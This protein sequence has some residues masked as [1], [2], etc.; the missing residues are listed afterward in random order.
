MSPGHLRPLFL[1]VFAILVIAAG[2]YLSYELGR[3]RAGYSLLD[4][5]RQTEIYEAEIARLE[6]AVEDLRR[7]QAIF[8]TSR[9]I[10]RE[11]YA[12]VESNLDQQQ[13][14]IQA[15]EEELAFYRGIVSPQDGKAGLR[16]QNLQV[17]PSDSEQNHVLKLMLVQAIM[18]SNRVSG[19]VRVKLIGHLDDEA[20]EFDLEQLATDDA[21]PELN[22]GFRYF[23]SL[24]LELSLP[25]GFQPDT[26]EVEI[27]PT[28]PRGEPVT[29]SF[30]WSA[31]RV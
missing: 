24:E 9:E 30:Q 26:V 4:E 23:Q 1:S 10:D 5:R 17:F 25:V 29:Q 21:S 2:L 19:V 13:A 11:T 27:W 18:Q 16:I 22:Y 7:Q 15:Q 31:V 8:E 20:A 14:R 28:E 3:D 12:R 6:L